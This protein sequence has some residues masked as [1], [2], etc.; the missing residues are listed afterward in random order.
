[1]DARAFRTRFPQI[2]AYVDDAYEAMTEVPVEGT[3]PV[4]ILALRS[5][6]STGID[7]VTGWPCFTKPGPEA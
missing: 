6:R 4:P 5:Q 1:M 7:A 3:E 2:S